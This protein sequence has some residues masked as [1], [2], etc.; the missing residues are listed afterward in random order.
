LGKKD[1]LIGVATS[2]LFL[3]QNSTPDLPPGD[4]LKLEVSDTGC[5]ITDEV[6]AEV[7]DPFFSTKFVAYSEAS[8]P[9]AAMAR[10]RIY[11]ESVVRAIH[12]AL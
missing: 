1:G 5:G 10:R 6:Q 9:P 2:H 3:A 12:L 11:F 7:F 4:C 8:A